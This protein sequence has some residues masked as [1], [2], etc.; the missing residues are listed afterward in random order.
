MTPSTYFLILLDIANILR[1]RHK[2][3]VVGV[4]QVAVE[5]RVVVL[6]LLGGPLLLPIPNQ[7]LRIIGVLVH[8]Y[9]FFIKLNCIFSI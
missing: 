3:G 2:L 4:R 8:F 6:I 7:R 9:L 5:D 1:N